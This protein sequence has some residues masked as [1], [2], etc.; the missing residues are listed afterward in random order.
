[1]T[2][3]SGA[4]GVAKSTSNFS[5]DAIGVEQLANLKERFADGDLS[6]QEFVDLFRE[7]ID[8]SLSETQLTHLY[9]CFL[10]YIRISIRLLLMTLP[11]FSYVDFNKLMPIAMDLWTG[12]SFRIS[13]FSARV[14][15]RV[16][17]SL[18]DPELDQLRLHLLRHPPIIAFSIRCIK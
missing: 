5:R 2:K 12:T 9:V 13:C 15:A 4:T 18:R 1:M 16:I 10:T 17:R 11:S 6:E 8:T 14:I 3:V 7:I